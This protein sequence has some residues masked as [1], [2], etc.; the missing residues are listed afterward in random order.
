[1]ADDIIR[2]DDIG[3]AFGEGAERVEVLKRLDLSVARGEF[4]AIVGASGVGKSTLLRILMGLAAPS[5]GSVEIARSEAFERDM[6]LVFQ[7]SRMLPW[8][9]ILANAAF[10]LEKLPL[11]KATRRKRALEALGIVGLAELAD[12]Y[13]RQLSGGQRQRVALA[14]ALAVK[15]AILLMDEPFSA[16][17]V[18]TREGL[19]DEISRI[20]GATGQTILFVTHDIDEAVFLAD[21]IVALG[22][23]PGEVRAQISVDAPR[24]RRRADPRLR[25]LSASIK[26]AIAAEAAGRD[27]W[28]I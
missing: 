19:Q 24:P 13:P 2:I 7:D 21:R 10:G 27:D 14:R 12:R 9:R 16:L 4:V 18:A 17:D 26:T 8:R 15:P 22:G 6:A 1:M 28:V 25:E 20:H 23:K 3:I 5:H 11:D